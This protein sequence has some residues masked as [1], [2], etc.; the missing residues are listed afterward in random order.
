[1]QNRRERSNTAS[2]DAAQE[3]YNIKKANCTGNAGENKR[4]DSRGPRCSALP[5][6]GSMHGARRLHMGHLAVQP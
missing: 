6:L 1:M 3:F 2:E 5:G 4:F